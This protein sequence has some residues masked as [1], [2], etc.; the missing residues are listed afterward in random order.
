MVDGTC[1]I[2][3]DLS[4]RPR[5]GA[6]TRQCTA[7]G[8]R[9]VLL[10]LALGWGGASSGCAPWAG[11]RPEP[12]LSASERRFYDEVESFGQV[13]READRVRLRGH[14]EYTLSV[15]PLLKAID[16]RG[17]L[18]VLDKL[19]VRTIYAFGD[20]GAPAGRIGGEGRGPGEYV[21]PH[22]LEYGGRSRS[23]F[24]YD[25]DL[26]RVSEFGEDFRFRRS[27]PL[28]LFV[29]Q[30]LVTPEGRTFCYSSSRPTAVPPKA[31]V[32]EIDDRGRVVRAFAP[33]S[34]RYSEWASSE[35][36]GIVYAR[37]WLYVIT[38]YEYEISVY[39]LSGDLV[40]RRSGASRRYVP[41]GRPP[42]APEGVDRFELS[43][44]YHRS[45]SHIRQLLVLDGRMVG[46]V[47]AEPGERRV[48][49]DLYELDLSPVAHDLELP[50]Y[51][52]DL[53]AH[54]DSLYAIAPERGPGGEAPLNP[55]V[56][57]YRLIR[58]AGEAAGPEIASR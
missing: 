20:D 26:L 9:V 1:G 8:A 48:V 36:G 47:H 52:G 27:F 15:R 13:F 7:P 33:Q 18:V 32:H 16:R 42:V 31:V 53:L 58:P 6:G 12:A 39:S 23:Y 17:R 24:V 50:D 14:Q 40:L 44:A 49:L 21:Y 43:Q 19:N 54:G 2:L 3:F 28:P 51:V 38:P 41:P 22:T 55:A 25:G 35:G 5:R 34:R 56:V 10:F 30:L 45:W 4:T 46:V 11:G 29:D 37:G 57:R